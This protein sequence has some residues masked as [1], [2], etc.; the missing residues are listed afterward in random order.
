MYTD[1]IAGVCLS[2]VKAH[3]KPEKLFHITTGLSEGQVTMDTGSSLVIVS[4]LIC[5]SWLQTTFKPAMFSKIL[6][7]RFIIFTHRR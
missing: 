6:R 5:I 1:T 4:L 3:N 7:L 2:F